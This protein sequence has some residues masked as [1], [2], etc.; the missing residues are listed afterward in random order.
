KSEIGFTGHF[1]LQRRRQFR[2]FSADS[3]KFKTIILTQTSKS[4]FF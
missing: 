1:R 4:P 2:V 3:P